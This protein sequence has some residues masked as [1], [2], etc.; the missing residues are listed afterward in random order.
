MWREWDKMVQVLG[1]KAFRHYE[2]DALTT[3]TPYMGNENNLLH[4]LKTN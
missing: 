3:I 2:N 4:P 1:L